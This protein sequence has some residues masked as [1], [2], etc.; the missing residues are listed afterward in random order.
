MAEH[1]GFCEKQWPAVSAGQ[2]GHVSCSL[3]HIKVPFLTDSLLAFIFLWKPD[4][5]N[6]YRN[7]F[8]EDRCILVPLLSLL[9]TKV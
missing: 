2:Q 3:G 6:N 7:V 9:I 1:R 8:K 5:Q 4:L